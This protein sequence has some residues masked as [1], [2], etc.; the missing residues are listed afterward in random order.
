MKKLSTYLFL[1]LF[2]FQTS[3]Q[4]DDIR[5]FQIEGMSIGDSLLDYFSEEEINNKMKLYWKK[6]YISILFDNLASFEVYD[7][8]QFTY[9]TND[10]KFK[11]YSIEGW[12]DFAYT[13]KNC[14]KKQDEIVKEL[15]SVFKN[16][17]KNIQKDNHAADK[18]GESKFAAVNFDFSSGDGARVICTDWGEKIS[19]EKN[20][21]DKLKVIL[22]SKEFKHFLTYEAYK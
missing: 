4:A 22:N 8:V 15:S 5:D 10:K 16:A 9:K 18:S 6:K 7:S 17:N 1:L 21:P 12:L 11:I 2:S 13:I 14:Y 3:S 20:W 19:K